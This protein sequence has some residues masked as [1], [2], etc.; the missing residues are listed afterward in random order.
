MIPLNASVWD[1]IRRI[2]DDCDKIKRDAET[3]ESEKDFIRFVEGTFKIQSKA[4]RLCQKA[5][6]IPIKSG[7]PRAKQRV[8][9]LAN[10]LLHISVTENESGWIKISIPALLPKK[11][12]GGVEY[13]RDSV[14][15][16]LEKYFL[17][18]QRNTFDVLSIMAFHHVY[19]EKYPLRRLRDHDNIE[20]N[21]IADLVALNF[22]I[23]DGPLVC[24]HMQYTSLGEEDLTEIYIVPA[25]IFSEWVCKVYLPDI[26]HQ[27]QQPVDGLRKEE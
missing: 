5:R 22:L 19:S 12:K 24:N 14:S 25:N 15:F 21:A 11:E 16:G 20:I 27:L 9:N 10:D 6:L 23:D 3:L 8:V 4:E 1:D 17:T 13:I 18:H 26:H 7:Y 2:A